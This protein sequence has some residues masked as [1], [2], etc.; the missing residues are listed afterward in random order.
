MFSLL[1]GLLINLDKHEFSAAESVMSSA[2]C[3]ICVCIHTDTCPDSFG[4]ALAPPSVNE[5]TCAIA[6]PQP[7]YSILHL[8]SVYVCVH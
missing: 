3:I 2:G 6:Q 8:N 1:I 5:N 4:G 7:V